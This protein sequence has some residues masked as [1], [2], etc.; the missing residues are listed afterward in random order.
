MAVQSAEIKIKKDEADR[1]MEA[2][3][4][5]LAAAKEALK[6]VSAAAITEIKALPQP[7]DAIKLVCTVAFHFYKNNKQDDWGSVK[8]IMLGDMKLL[9]G[10][11]NYDI[12]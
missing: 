5:A 7:P 11:K 3:A 4:P 12:T 1:D 8:Q 6:Q 10:L 2:A 9:D